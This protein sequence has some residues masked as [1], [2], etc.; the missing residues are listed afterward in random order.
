MGTRQHATIEALRHSADNLKAA[1][2][3]T[4]ENPGPRAQHLL[5]DLATAESRLEGSGPMWLGTGLEVAKK[6]TQ[7]IVAAVGREPESSADPRAPGGLVAVSRPLTDLNM[8]YLKW[9][10]P[11]RP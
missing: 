10:R 3:A 7:A 2:S 6:L 8:R 1:L 9:L 11:R 4:V 5:E